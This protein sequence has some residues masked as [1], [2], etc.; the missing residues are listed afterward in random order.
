MLF[1]LVQIHLSEMIK[2]VNS[3]WYVVFNIIYIINVYS[4]MSLIP[5]KS[6]TWAAKINFGKFNMVLLFLAYLGSY[7]LGKI[8]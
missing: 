7:V 8:Y 4:V 5:E 3:Q 6:R 2:S 1:N